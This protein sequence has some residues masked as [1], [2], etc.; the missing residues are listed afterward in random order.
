MQILDFLSL[1]ADLSGVIKD[2]SEFLTSDSSFKLGI[3]VFGFIEQKKET[4]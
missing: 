4:I 3:V 1:V 2:F